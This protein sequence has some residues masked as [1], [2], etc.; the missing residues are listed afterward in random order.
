MNQKNWKT[1][2]LQILKTGAAKKT[3]VVL[4]GIILLR[5]GVNWIMHLKSADQMLAVKVTELSFGSVDKTLTL[6]GNIEAIEQA[7]LYAHVSGYLK[8]LLVDEGDV[9]KKDQLLGV[10]DAPDIIQEF[11]NAKS[12]Y[13]FKET[14]RKRYQELLKENVVS[15]Q[16]YDKV[17]AEANQSKARYE[18][19]SANL[20]YT[21]VRAPFAGS[22]ARR[23]KYPGDFISAPT[24]GGV[25]SP[26]FLLVNERNLRVVVN[27]PQKE[28]SSVSVGHLVDIR[29]DTF[30]DRKFSG[31]VSR[32][33]AVL[34]EATKTQR[35]LID[36]QNPGDDLHTGMYASIVLH[37]VRKDDVPML[38]KDAVLTD[39]DHS[40][41][42]S[43][44]Q[45]L[46]KK[47]PVEIGDTENGLTEIRSPV[48][49]KKSVFVVGGGQVLADHQK[50]EV[51]EI[52]S[53]S[54]QQKDIQYGQI[55]AQDTVHHLSRCTHNAR[56]RGVFDDEN[57]TRYPADLQIT[58]SDG[59][60]YLHGYAR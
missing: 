13:D 24:K 45:G 33:D 16:E 31:E 44:D 38:P 50:V 1:D 9:V 28:M 21:S 48:F 25:P 52:L 53:G 20:D 59:S 7:T 57:A 40:Y 2:L 19:A 51:T 15:Q 60:H 35:A 32:V 22:I 27:I 34:D 23:F 46:V 36:I 17:N 18:N 43:V 12:E 39:G 14:T 5:L 6:P 29:V 26:L 8:K 47:V 3:G 37:A 54:G 42:Y 58:G 55:C 56:D 30:P 41:V 49:S 11:R 10:I 4:V